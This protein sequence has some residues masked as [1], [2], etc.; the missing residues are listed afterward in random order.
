MFVIKDAAG[1][2]VQKITAETKAGINKVVWNYRYTSTT[3]IK[4][5]VNK[6]GRYG[7][8]DVGQLALPGTYSVTMYLD[9]NG[10]VTQLAEPKSFEIDLLNNNSLAAA[11]KNELLAFQKEVAELRRSVQ[12]TSKLMGEIKDRLAHIKKAIQTFPSVDVSL[13]EEVKKIQAE[14]EEVSI[15]LY[16]DN[17]IAKYE[18]E[19][20][21]SIMDR[22]EI[23]VYGLWNSTSAPTTTSKDNITIAKNEYEPVLMMV[24][25]SVKKVEALEKS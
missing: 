15:M 3:P 18:F 20:Y 11:D 8:F 21:P 9:D 23:V 5:K 12:G 4:L 2:E 17:A 7:S 16:G 6:P 1:N 22:I 10:K 13:L 14:L 24:Q 25:Q 19:T